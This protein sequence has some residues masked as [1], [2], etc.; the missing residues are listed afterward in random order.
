[1]TMHG[2]PAQLTSQLRAQLRDY[3]GFT[4]AINSTLKSINQIQAELDDDRKPVSLVKA[5]LEK[6][7]DTLEEQAHDEM[8]RLDHAI[9]TLDALM[10]MQAPVALENALPSSAKR[11]NPNP[12]KRKADASSS[13]GSPVGSS[14]PSPLPSYPSRA[15]SPAQPAPT[16]AR[17]GP[18]KQTPILPSHPLP[19]MSSSSSSAGQHPPPTPIAP[20]LQ[21]V[22]GPPKKSTAKGRKEALQAQLPLRPGRAIAV[23]QSKKTIPGEAPGD[24]ILGRIISSLQGDKNRY[25]VEDVDY[26]PA[27]PTPEGGKWNTTM[28][29]IIPLPEK[30]DE[31][32]Y[33][34][35]PYPAGTPVLALYPETTSFY[36]AFIEG[37]PYLVALGNGKT[38]TKERV[39]KLK[40]DDDGDVVRD[41]P[42]ELVV[43][44][45]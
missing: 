24:W 11:S 5:R 37:G 6:S 1:M 22:G 4:G 16:T 23:R 36:R 31:R 29:S 14:A 44:S 21:Q 15:G 38:K 33:P 19:P 10:A 13:A 18:T 26:D 9:A 25:A 17:V 2:D 7:Y 27:N 8:R 32:T 39:Y 35:H 42:I 45:T 28:K 43:E 41:V 34:E 12:K 20:A 40:F 3:L 30:T